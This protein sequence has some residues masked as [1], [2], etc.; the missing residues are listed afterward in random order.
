MKT[1]QDIMDRYGYNTST[2]CCIFF[3]IAFVV[4][5]AALIYWVSNL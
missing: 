4:A 5:V 1:D 2:G 3:V